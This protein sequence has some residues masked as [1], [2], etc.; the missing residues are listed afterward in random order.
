PASADD[1]LAPL[2]PG[3]RAVWSLEKATR[4]ITPTRECVSINGLWRWQ[5]A[6]PDANEAPRDDWGHFKVPGSLPGVT[7]YLQHDSQAH[8]PPPCWRDARPAGIAAAWYRR[9]ITSPA[10]WTGRRIVLA[11]E[12]LNSLA[13]VFVDGGQAGELRFPGGEIDLTPL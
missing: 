9:E 11:A 2:P 5:P 10:A 7:D 6:V 13:I 3:A 4:E 12:Y 8:F 1:R